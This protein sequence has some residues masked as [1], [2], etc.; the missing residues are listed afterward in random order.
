MLILGH[1]VAAGLPGAHRHHQRPDNAVGHGPGQVAGPVR[2]KI[3]RIAG[4][5]QDARHTLAVGQ[6]RDA[7]KP[8]AAGMDDKGHRDQSRQQEHQKHNGVRQ[9]HAGRA[10][11]DGEH[12][13]RQPHDHRAG[14]IAEAGDAAHQGRDP[15]NGGE[16]IGADGDQHNHR[17]KPPQ[18]L[19]LEAAA[20]ILRQGVGLAAADIAAKQA[21]AV[22]VA[23]GLQ[24]A[25]NHNAHEEA[26][27]DFPGVPQKGAGGEEG[28]NQGAHDQQRRRI[29]AG[30]VV[31]VGV[32]HLSA[33]QDAH[34]EKHNQGE[35]NTD[36]IDV[37]LSFSLSFFSAVKAR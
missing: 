21:R 8:A 14:G 10:G 13:K 36:D 26:V 9:Q 5:G 25:H 17:R 31:V 7:A 4:P 32:F 2:V 18:P 3:V 34:Q 11:I 12:R 23:G 6:L 24:H 30:N 16:Q 28:G 19:R 37:H 27:I 20:E 33:C 1:Q 22:D 29:A 35:D 15:L